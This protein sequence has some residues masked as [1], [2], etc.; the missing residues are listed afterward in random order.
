MQAVRRPHRDRRR[1]VRARA[2]R[3][4][5]AD[6]PQRRR[7]DDADQ[8]ADRRAQAERGRRSSSQGEDVTELPRQRAR[9]PRPVAHLPDQPAVPRSDPARSRSAS[10]SPSATVAAPTSGAS[11]AR[12]QRSSPRSTQLLTRFGLEADMDRPTRTLPYG[13]QRLLEIALALACPAEGAAARRAGRGRA[14]GASGATFSPRSPRCRRRGDPADRAR[15]GP[16][17]QLRRP[18][19]GAGRRPRPDRGRRPRRSPPTS[20][21]ARSISGRT[22]MAELLRVESLERRLR[23]GA[24]HRRRSTSRSRTDVR[25][26]LLGR[27]GVGKTTLINR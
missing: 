23:R 19:H 25:S 13:K 18:H 9:A 21:C 5:G 11:P 14:G 6:R 8:S 4:A 3:A 20:G 26:P 15:H 24:R 22:R 1:V 2:G 12:G 10:R 16:R 27:N 17:L 7:Q